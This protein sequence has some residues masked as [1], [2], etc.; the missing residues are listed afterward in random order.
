MQ[1]PVIGY[2]VE[3]N[4]WIALSMVLHSLGTNLAWHYRRPRSGR[5]GH[6]AER[7]KDWAYIPWLLQAMRFLYYIGIPYMALLRGIALPSL[8]G[9]TNLNWFEGIGWGTFFGLGAFLLLAFIWRYHLRSLASWPL[10]GKHSLDLTLDWRKLVREAVYQE[11]HW[12]FYRCGPTLLFDDH[13]P[14]VFLGLLL[15][16]LE[17]WSDP[18]WRSS[19]TRPGQAE[20]ALMGWSIAFV[21]ALI[22]LFVRNLWLVLPI[23]FALSWGLLRM[24]AALLD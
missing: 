1:I 15:N 13:Y 2:K 6:W 8:M 11:V 16:S 19:L 4:L 7:A 9:L 3:L 5:F 23:H 17:W 24:Q 21:M 18:A 22:Y 10:R 14:G 20:G 12:A